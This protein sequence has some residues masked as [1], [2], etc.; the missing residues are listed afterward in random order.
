MT[1]ISMRQK[2]ET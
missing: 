1:K 2:R